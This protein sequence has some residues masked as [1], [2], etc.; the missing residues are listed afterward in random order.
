MGYACPECRSGLEFQRVFDGRAAVSCAPC[1]IGAV[2]GFSRNRDEVYL[3][4]LA[5]YDAGRVSGWGGP[6]DGGGG[7]KGGGGKGGDG[8]GPQL[9]GMIRSAGEIKEIIGRNRPGPVTRAVLHSRL[10]YIAHYTV[11][12]GT[13]PAMGAAVDEIV[14]E[15]GMAELL[16]NMG[17]ARF[18][19]FQEEAVR[20]I[21]R[22]GNVVIEA[23]TASGKTEAFAVPII[24]GIR[25]GGTRKGVSAVFVYPTKALA[26]DQLPKISRIAES[27][28]VVVGVFDG[29]TER[30]ERARI[31]EGPPQIIITNFDVLHHHLWHR[32]GFSRL[33]AAARF[34]VVDEVHAYSGI[35]G[36]NVHYV[37][38]RLKRICGEGI[39]FVA[40]SA[41]IQ[42]AEGFCGRLFGEPVRLIRGEGKR[43]DT[44][45]AMVFPS[46]R[47]QGAL[48][49]DLTEK[50]VGGGHKTMAFSNS[51]L[52]AEL[53]ADQAKRRGVRIGVHRAGLAADHRRAVEAA[54]RGDGLDAVS[55]TPTM[56]LGM[57]V[58][59]VDG[60]VSATVPVNRLLQRMG[61]AARG[62]QRGYAFLAL[63]ND[64]ISQYYRN[65][66]GDYFED[67][68]RS[69]I[70]PG[71]PF[72][73]ECQVLAMACDRPLSEREAGEHAG[74][75]A[76]HVRRG[77]LR[78]SGG[79]YLPN[80]DRA[81]PLLSEYSIRG[82]GGSIDIFLDSK[83]V[84]DRVLPAA[85]G[86]LHRDAIYFLGGTRYRV[87]ELRYPE[88]GRAVLERIP[89]DWPYYTRALVEEWPTIEETYDRRR[90]FGVEVAFCRLRIRR[91]VHGYANIRFGAEAGQGE[92]VQLE[93]PLEYGLVTKG[94][95]FRAPRPAGA[96]AEAGD[97]DY[98]EA[99]GYHAT[100]HVVIEGG[101]MITGGV[102]QDLGGISMGISGMIF[103]Y[104]AA[105]GGSGASRALYDRFEGVAERGLSIVG[106]CPCSGE[107][108]C[109]RCTYSY[110]CGNNNEFLHKRASLEVFQRITAGEETVMVDPSAEDRPLV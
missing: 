29:D 10:D 108:G 25:S 18:Y 81:V 16:K 110:R 48:M 46:L 78:E 67:M 92:R 45:F 35:F 85:L 30:G 56:E 62:G 34:M 19:A 66:P 104:D 96:V 98:V 72:V 89:A 4:F 17:I 65:H 28:G 13:E 63:G 42:D 9:Q 87:R 14:Q 53:L 59:G 12:G 22:G 70:D 32:T 24:Q 50:L 20:E 57:D 97:G 105:V 49:A 84:G 55:C 80:M 52:G 27:A 107:S 38:K 90:A 39:Q 106:E 83:K 41:T 54:F 69:Y 37:I 68:E 5:E 75:V 79:R 8:G 36:T 6:T 93:T 51:H 77:N 2:V 100:E 88:R 21:T 43:G 58:G 60:V 11:I 86:E 3:D 102:S 33:L 71:N 73:E 91:S 1:G 103:V 7:G 47:T 26:R 23:P 74:V 82:I 101:N 31:L 109:P 95:V 99:S 61:R 44:D 94:I 76:D 64:P 15:K 40:A